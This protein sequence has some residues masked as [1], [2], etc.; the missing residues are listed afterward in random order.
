MAHKDYDHTTK[1]TPLIQEY[2][3]S[4][5][6]NT[7]AIAVEGRNLLSVTKSANSTPILTLVD[8]GTTITRLPSD[9]YKALS[10]EFRRVMRTKYRYKGAFYDCFDGFFDTCFVPNSN[11]IH[12]P[13]V[14]FTFQNNVQVNL[15]ASGTVYVVNKSLICFAFTNGGADWVTFGNTQQKTFEVVYDVAGQKLGFSSG[16]MC[17]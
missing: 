7:I 8:S 9:V 16:G 17:T 10:S 13:S 6:V 15:D 3:T 14:S 12:V 2:P 1:F 5:I 11:K 4:Y